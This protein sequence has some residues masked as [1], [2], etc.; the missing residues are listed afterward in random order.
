LT[1]HPYNVIVVLFTNIIFQ[2]IATNKTYLRVAKS[3]SDSDI[4]GLASESTTPSQI[5]DELTE[6]EFAWE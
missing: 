1:C 4:H 3:D 5:V 6:E 2:N